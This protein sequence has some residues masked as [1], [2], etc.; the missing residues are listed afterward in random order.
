MLRASFKPEFLNRIDDII[1]FNALGREE[2]SRIVDLQLERLRA[3]LAER[4]IDLELTGRAREVLFNQGYDPDYGARPLRRALQRL[5]QDPLALKLLNGEVHSGDRLLVDADSRPRG[6]GLPDRAAVSRA[7][8]IRYRPSRRS[9][10]PL[11]TTSEASRTLSAQCPRS[12]PCKRR[13][14]PHAEVQDSPRRCQRMTPDAPGVSEI[15][16]QDRE[17]KIRVTDKR[18]W[19][20]DGEDTPARESSA[21][22]K[23][24][25]VEELEKRRAE[26]EKKVE[27]V[28]A[29]YRDFRDKSEAENRQR[30]GA[31][32]KRVRETA[33][34]GSGRDG[35]EVHRHIREL[36]EGSAARP[37]IVRDREGLLE[38]VELIHT[39]F[40]GILAELGLEEV[41]GP[42]E[43]YDPELAEAVA[44]TEV[45]EQ[46]KDNLILEVV[47][48]G[49]RLNGKLVRPARVRVGQVRD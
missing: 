14:F 5:I 39:Q 25:Y 44:V 49:Y 26:A 12:I 47:R 2:I 37:S 48:K 16:D 21:S 17:V 31:H 10:F 40:G 35:R 29:S 1:I 41:A 4:K 45:S 27:E 30:T 11:R 34:T 33:S 23:P 7:S 20:Q 19:V 3:R 8:L 24:T 46:E 38:G 28:I 6:N 36:R 22:L 43:S 32:W 13:Q 42:G 18:F 15:G 9:A